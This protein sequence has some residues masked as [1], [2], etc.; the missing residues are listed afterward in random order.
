MLAQN[1]QLQLIR[2]PVPVSGS[3]PGCLSEDA[4]GKRT[5]VFFVIEGRDN[6]C[7]V[8]F[9][10]CFAHKSDSLNCL[11]ALGTQ[12]PKDDFGLLDNKSMIGGG[13]QA[14]GMTYGTVH[15][16]R[17]TAAAADDVMVIVSHP[18]LI[19]SRMTRRLDAPDKACLF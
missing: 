3:T 13:F 7:G 14:G 19:A 17:H 11:L 15:I 9:F 16:G 10:G 5:R 2:P 18:C 1:T 4:S 12:A 6:I 8:T